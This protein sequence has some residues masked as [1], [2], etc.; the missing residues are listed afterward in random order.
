MPCLQKNNRYDRRGC[1]SKNDTTYI[2]SVCT[3]RLQ[4]KRFSVYFEAADLERTIRC[5]KYEAIIKHQRTHLEQVM[6]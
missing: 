5:V 3:P 2:W 4:G 6:Q 1:K